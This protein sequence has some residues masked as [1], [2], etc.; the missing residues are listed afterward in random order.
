MQNLMGGELTDRHKGGTRMLEN[1]K[2]FISLTAVSL[3]AC[4]D[5]DTR[6][7]SLPGAAGLRLPVKFQ[8][9]S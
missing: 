3:N 4:Q 1:S 5:S 9:R 2:P 6:E 8:I 7:L